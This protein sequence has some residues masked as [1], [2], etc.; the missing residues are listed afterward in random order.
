MAG[1]KRDLAFFRADGM[2]RCGG[3]DVAELAAEH[4][5]PLFLYSFDLVRSRFRALTEAFAGADLL[6]AYS[7]KA[8]G[9]L[10]LLNRLSAL[11]AGADIV[12]G[13][14]LFRALKAGVP[15][16]RIVFGGVGKREDELRAGLEAG[17]HAFNVETSGELHR[18][19]ELARDRGVRAPV[20]IRINPGI[21]APTP[22]EYTRTGHAGA[23]FGLPVPVAVGLYRWAAT[24]PSLRVRGIDVH[25]GSQ[26]AEVG[27]YKRALRAVMEVVHLLKREGIQ[28]EYVDMGGGFG[29]PGEGEG[30]DLTAL[31]GALLP[32]L[33][34]SGLRLILEPGRFLVGEAGLLVTRV[35][36]LKRSEEKTFVIVDAGMTEL[37]RPSHY[38]GFHEIEPVSVESDRELVVADVVG[39]VCETGDFLARDRR[40]PLP[41]PGEYVAVLNAGAY[42]FSM[43]SNYNARPRPAEVLVDG[44]EAFLVRARESYDDLIRGE[45]IP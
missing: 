21:E 28:L 24:R 22:H 10:S 42:A 39:P 6:L 27:P 2:L 45:A 26:I 30:M 13:G 23:K 40:L 35:E 32:L 8:N 38:G 7:V 43:A 33:E 36:A 29:I 12:S 9:N 1:S 4:G 15:P 19:E 3:L 41:R 17:I 14:E 25:I 31:A 37:L 20:G 44:G 5:T 16:G 18:L 11:G 34:G